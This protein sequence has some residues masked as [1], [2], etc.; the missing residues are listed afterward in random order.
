VIVMTLHFINIL[1]HLTLH[2]I[3]LQKIGHNIC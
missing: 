2:S 1:G 3:K